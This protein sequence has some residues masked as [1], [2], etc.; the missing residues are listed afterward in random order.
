MRFTARGLLLPPLLLGFSALLAASSYAAPAS[1]DQQV[2]G[3]WE[4][5]VHGGRWIWIIG[6]NGTYE[7]HSEAPDSVAS[8]NG[9]FSASEGRW[10]LHATDGYA[11]GGTYQNSPTGTFLATGR[12]GTAAWNHPARAEAN[13]DMIGNILGDI[14][15]D[16][17]RIAPALDAG[18]ING[19][20]GAFNCHPCDGPQ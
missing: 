4:L 10:S 8:H 3:L 7:F 1:V 20:G 5:P 19:G 11:D 16:G 12:F 18:T 13:I 15:A 14:A 6:A 9:S 2:V 17:V